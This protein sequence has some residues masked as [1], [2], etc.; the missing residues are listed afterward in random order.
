MGSRALYTAVALIGM[1]VAGG[2]AWWWQ[3]RPAPAASA[4]P[5]S[6]AG[7]RT[8]APGPSGGA[9]GPATVEV[10]PAQT[11]TLA[12]DAQAVGSLRSRQ[13][14][15]VRPEVSGRIARLGFVDGQRV[16]KGQ[17][18]VQLDDSLPQAQLRQAEAQAAI[19]RTN[20]QRSRELLGQGF[21]STSAVDQNAA[22]LEVADAQVALARAQVDRMRVLAPFDG[23]L[24]IRQ[25]DVGDYV[26]DGADLVPLE[27]LS[28]M[29][30]DFRLPERYLGGMRAGLPAE[31]TIDAL[32]GQRFGAR[33][34]AVDAVIDPDGRALRARAEVDNPGSRLKPGMFARVRVVF[35]VRENA[36]VVPE[37]ALVPLGGRQY[38]FRVVEGEGGQRVAER[39]EARVG[40]RTPGRAE[41]LDGVRAGDVVVT[42]GQARIAGSERAPVRVVELGA[43]PG[44]ARPAASSAASR[45]NGAT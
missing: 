43:A 9:R 2:A 41:L 15:V 14:V 8:A 42:A 25:V 10:A 12:D 33:I 32:P 11:M 27:D 6:P 35:A 16:R 28:A 17:V 45:P 5:S 4:G 22:A 31:V 18:L 26:K 13:S 36:V 23:T 7:P 30:V 39:I 24:G 1:A 38:V 40:L 37:E 19:A 44:A 20:L 3:N 21:V 29:T 34:V